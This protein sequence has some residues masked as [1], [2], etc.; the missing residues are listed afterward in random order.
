[1]NVPSSYTMSS[2]LAEIIMKLKWLRQPPN[3]NPQHQIVAV[4]FDHAIDHM[5]LP[6]SVRLTFLVGAFGCCPVSSLSVTMC[7]CVIGRHD[8]PQVYTPSILVKLI[9][10]L[11]LRVI[12]FCRSLPF[13]RSKKAR[14]LLPDA[15]EL[16]SS[17]RFRHR[18]HR[19]C[20]AVPKYHIDKEVII[21]STHRDSYHC[22][23][24]YLFN[25]IPPPLCRVPRILKLRKRQ[26]S[27]R[28]LKA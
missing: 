19:T 20:L 9:P 2:S 18:H 5:Q 8:R 27:P 24:Y 7:V 4:L 3:R 17:F 10:R 12:R 14:G 15:A 26:H 25:L 16:A 6:L 22:D 21:R 13:S 23:F 28:G 11:H 1:M